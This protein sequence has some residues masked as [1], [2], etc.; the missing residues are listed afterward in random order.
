MTPPT[1]KRI[2]IYSDLFLLNPGE[3]PAKQLGLSYNIVYHLYQIL[4]YTILITDSKKQ[5]ILWRDRERVNPISEGS[6]TVP[7]NKLKNNTNLC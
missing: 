1:Q 4:R 7:I 3:E 5:I 2:K 6:F